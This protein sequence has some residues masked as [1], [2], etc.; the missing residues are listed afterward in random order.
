[1]KITF[2][3]TNGWFD[4]DTGN[5]IC[6][7]IET[8]QCS[9]VLD[10]GS[11]L[12]KLDKYIDNEKPIYLFLS[13]FHLDHVIG[14][15]CKNKFEFKQ[16]INIY[17]QR[18]TKG[19]LD[20][21]INQPFTI[22]FKDKAMAYEVKIYDL[23]ARKNDLPFDLEIAALSH[24]SPCVGFRFQLE[25]KIISYFIDTGPCKEVLKLA[26]DADLLIAEC[27]FK[28][29]E[30][31]KEQTHLNPQ[32]V[33]EIA[34]KAGVKRLVLTHFDAHRYKTLEER[35]K[36]EKFAKKLFKNTIVAFDDMQIKI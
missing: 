3:G 8:D 32:I 9:I 2:L 12:Y 5:T 23:P 35:K 27:S 34:Q 26:R 13:H 21:I 19:I 30:Y 25:G 16:G 4:T 10:A 7:L 17:G 33:T 24:W 22:P 18:G 31:Y 14:L 28:I 6:T 36:S 15:H 1:M 11:G 29:N 20:K